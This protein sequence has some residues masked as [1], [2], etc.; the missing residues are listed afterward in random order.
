MTAR[1]SGALAVDFG[2]GYE[3]KRGDLTGHIEYR[4]PPRAVYACLRC[5]T[6]EGPVT[7]PLAVRRFVDTVRAVHATRCHPAAPITERQAA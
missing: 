7:G 4:R 3:I 6:Q 1:M 5:G 2:D